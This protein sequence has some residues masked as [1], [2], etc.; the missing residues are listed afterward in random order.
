MVHVIKP[1]PV[2]QTDYLFCDTN[3]SASLQLILSCGMSSS[4]GLSSAVA[5]A[6]GLWAVSSSVVSL[7]HS[8][9]TLTSLFAVSTLPPLNQPIKSL[10][11]SSFQ[12]LW[13][14]VTIPPCAFESLVWK[15]SPFMAGQGVRNTDSNLIKRPYWFLRDSPTP[16]EHS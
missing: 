14:P 6:C 8:Y 4:L 11:L 15:S 3:A 12:V 7:S 5:L 1:P 10:A 2:H 13:K 16:P 9:I